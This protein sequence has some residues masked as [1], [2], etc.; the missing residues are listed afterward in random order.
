MNKIS[1]DGKLA[2]I[3]THITFIGPIIAYFINMD[4]KDE[5]GSFYIRQSV[6]ILCLFLVIGALI[7]AV[8]NA[9]AA[10]GFILFIFILWVY[11]FIG[12]LTNQ[13]RLLPVIGIYFQQWFRR[14]TDDTKK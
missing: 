11:S 12:A 2:A 10:Y 4:D 13:Y 3:I 7:G 6:G 9:W 5:F 14:K 8:P 1:K